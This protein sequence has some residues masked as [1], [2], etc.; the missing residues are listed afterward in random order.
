MPE[1]KKSPDL[2][3]KC[4]DCSAEWMMMV[5]AVDGELDRLGQAF[6]CFK[7]SVR[8]GRSIVSKKRHFCKKRYFCKKKWNAETKKLPEFAK[9]NRPKIFK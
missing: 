2:V 7:F 1:S 5:V 9:R 3:K 4:H 8:S 6:S